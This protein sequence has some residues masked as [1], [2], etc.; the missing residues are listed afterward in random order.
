[1]RAPAPGAG[2]RKRP[3]PASTATEPRSAPDEPGAGRR[4]K[5]DASPPSYDAPS[6]LTLLMS[7]RLASAPVPQP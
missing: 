6:A 2:A 7:L 5:G 1:L 3:A 4:R